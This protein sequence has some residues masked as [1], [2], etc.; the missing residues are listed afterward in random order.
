M[1][2]H[3]LVVVKRDLMQ[4]VFIVLLSASAR[5]ADYPAVAVPAGGQWR[6]MAGKVLTPEAR[7]KIDPIP[8]N[9]V[10]TRRFKLTGIEPGAYRVGFVVGT[11]MQRNSPYE[12]LGNY[13]VS[14]EGGASEA[15]AKAVVVSLA[16][17]ADPGLKPQRKPDEVGKDWAAWRGFAVATQPLWLDTHST[18]ALAM[19][20]EQIDIIPACWLQKIASPQDSVAVIVRVDAIDNAFTLANP[21]KLFIAAVNAARTA[22]AGQVRIDC[23]DMLTE[24]TTADFVDCRVEGTGKT[25]IIYQP[26]LRYGVFRLAV[27]PTVGKDASQTGFA[28]SDLV[29]AYG[30]ARMAR[31]LPEDWP[32]GA[33]HS[34]P[35]PILK[36]PMPGFKWYRCFNSW[37][38]ME[39]KRGQFDWKS[40]DATIADMKAIGGKLLLAF[41]G[42]PAWSSARAI[43]NKQSDSRFAPDNVD[44]YRNFLRALIRRYDDGSGVLGAIE[45][46]NEYNANLRWQD[47]WD[48]LVE[49]HKA[50]YEE[51]RATNGR[52]KTVG[53]AISPGHHVG[54]V[55]DLTER[56]VLKYCDIVSGHFYEEQNS[57]GRYNPRN[58]LELHVDM[59]RLP[60]IR[61]RRC[62]PIWDTE[63]GMGYEGAN[64][65]PRPGGRMATQDEVL[66]QLH[67][68]KDFDP[69]EPWALWPSSSERRMAARSVT[70]TVAMLGQG[71]EKR[72]F[73]HPNWYSL[74]HALV[75]PWVSNATL[76]SV[77]E[78]VDFHYVVPLGVNAVGGAD[79]IGG[80]AYRIGKPGQ[81]Q[82]VVVWA[83]RTNPKHPFS[84][85][86]TGWLSPVP[87]QLP[88]AADNEVTVQDMYLRTSKTVKAQKYPRGDAVTIEAGE[89]PVFVWNWKFRD[90]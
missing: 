7:A 17:P 89:E 15:A 5:A 84:D 3:L 76:G 52:I 48:K 85:G 19:G 57:L 31:E 49:M 46:W 62:L 29:F 60:M 4:I 44:D 24:K 65:G 42:A 79:D 16:P 25:E 73:F 37:S 36:A 75:L 58:N 80:L 81:K 8:I 30:P 67:A 23:C 59:L 87:I 56:G 47:N 63:S 50:T 77:L 66:R 64:G 55:E 13:R 27:H 86:W 2:R 28:S 71:V 69:K 72:F 12:W 78:Q 14:V 26:K 70:G 32:L 51:T 45:V 18:L 34:N 6:N 74:D 43:Q 11:G 83:E 68:R 35:S 10:N 38:Y 53:I 1:K 54:Y 90:Q 40:M 21:P 22:F 9:G 61:E 88:C 41:E 39:P 33:H 82:V 20:S